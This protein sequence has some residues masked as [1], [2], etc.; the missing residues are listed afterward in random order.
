MYFLIAV[1]LDF[2]C[3]WNLCKTSR[4]VAYLFKILGRVA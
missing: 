2:E 4:R 3:I 1:Y